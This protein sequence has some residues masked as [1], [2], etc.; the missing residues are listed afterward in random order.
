MPVRKPVRACVPVAH[1]SQDPRVATFVKDGPIR[2]YQEP[3]EPKFI[4]DGTQEVTLDRSLEY[5]YDRADGKENDLFGHGPVAPFLVLNLF[6]ATE[7]HRKPIGERL[8]LGQN[9]RNAF[10]SLHSTPSATSI[11]EYNSYVSPFVQLSPRKFNNCLPP[12][13]T[14]F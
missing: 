14:C 2:A 7:T 13:D 9:L 3:N 8:I 6:R 12:G 5:F 11:N 10:Y 4:A 1:I